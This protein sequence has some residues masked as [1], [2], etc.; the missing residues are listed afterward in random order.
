MY[1]VLLVLLLTESMLRLPCWCL[2]QRALHKAH[3]LSIN[4]K[5]KSTAGSFYDENFVR[6]IEIL[7]YD[8][9]KV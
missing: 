7:D 5:K 8:D 4:L 2:Q 9:K 6:R 3:S 1:T